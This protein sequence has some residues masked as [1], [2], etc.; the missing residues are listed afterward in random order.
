MSFRPLDERTYR[1]YI[2][3]VGWKLERGSIDY[4]LYDDTGRFLCAIKIAHGKRSEKGVVAYS[5]QKTKNEFKK[6]GWQW[7]PKEK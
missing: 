4:K 6:R 5:V 7:P 1:R 3:Q 2:E